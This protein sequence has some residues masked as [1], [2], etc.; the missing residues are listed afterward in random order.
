MNKAITD[1][2]TMRDNLVHHD[3]LFLL[4]VAIRFVYSINFLKKEISTGRIPKPPFNLEIRSLKQVT[5]L[6][7]A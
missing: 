7:W 6:F 3:E 2:A 4:V 1:T 5:S